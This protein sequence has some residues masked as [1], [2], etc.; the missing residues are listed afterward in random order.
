MLIV[1]KVES[2]VAKLANEADDVGGGRPHRCLIQRRLSLAM[3]TYCV[4]L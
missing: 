2:G 3:A 4:C 1:E